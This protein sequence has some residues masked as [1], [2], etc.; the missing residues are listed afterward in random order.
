MTSEPVRAAASILAL[1]FLL[2]LRHATDADHV[3]AVTTIVARERRLG[4]ASMVGVLWGLGHTLTLL[5]VGGAIVVFKLAVPARCGLALEAAVATMLVALGWVNLARTGRAGDDGLR[6]EPP[7]FDANDRPRASARA[8]GRALFVGIVHG[9][10]G[11]AAVALLVLSTIGDSLLAFAYLAIFGAGTV[12]GMALL[13]TAVGLPFAV[14]VGRF[15]RFNRSLARLTG[16]ASLVFGLFIAY[17]IIFVHGLFSSRA[18]W[19][20][21]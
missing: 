3:V 9:L 6:A 18:S 1:G 21:G 7:A 13:T 17:E 11:S 20:P 2:G 4:A 19:T 15:E 8:G 10:A 14:A 16:L 5:V 12:A